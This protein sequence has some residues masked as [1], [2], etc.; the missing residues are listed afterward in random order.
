MNSSKIYLRSLTTVRELQAMNELEKIIWGMDSTIPYHQTITA[1]K[2]GGLILG[3]YLDNE[4]VGFQYSFAGFDG[5][6]SYLCSH[7]LGVHPKYQHLGIGKMLKLMQKEEALKMGYRLITWTFDPLES[8]NGYFNIRK[9]GAVGKKYIE[10]CYEQ[11][12]DNLNT[13]LPSDRLLAEWWI[14]STHVEKRENNNLQHLL[15]DKSNQTAYWAVNEKG[16]PI[17]KEIILSNHELPEYLFVPIPIN[18]QEIKKIDFPL[19]LD[20]RLKTRQILNYYF[21]RNWFI[22]DFW[23]ETDKNKP[24]NYYI[25]SSGKGGG[26]KL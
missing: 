18:I 1:V 5:K 23:K 6:M 7:M 22:I 4:L 12:E 24:I 21:Q 10:N 2:N 9:L 8:V 25:L 13:G 15:P 19:A 17:V 26:D 16:L 14:T 20:W 11:M 3:A